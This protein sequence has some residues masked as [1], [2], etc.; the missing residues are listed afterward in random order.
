VIQ[1]NCKLGGIPWNVSLRLKGLL[2]IGFDVTHDARDK[3]KSYGAM[4]ASL[5]PSGEH[6]GHYFSAVNQHENG[7]QLSQH[8]GLNIIEAIRQYSDLNS[9]EGDRV[10]PDRILIYR[11]GVGDGQVSAILRVLI[12][13]TNFLPTGSICSRSRTQRHQIEG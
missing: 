12:R 6:G 1:V 7:E 5:N 10:L 9:N 4:V 8:F 3:R 2:I 11:D 13:K